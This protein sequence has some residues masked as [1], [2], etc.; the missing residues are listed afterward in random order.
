[1]YELSAKNGLIL[2]LDGLAPEGGEAQLWVI[3]ELQSNLTLRSG[4][5][6]C[7]DQPTFENFLSP[8]IKHGLKVSYVLSDKQ[9]GL[10]PAVASVFG[11]ETKHTFCQSH[12]LKNL[13]EPL[14]EAD[15]AMKV[16]LRKT[17]RIGVG[18]LIRQEGVESPGVLIVTGLLPTPI[19]EAQTEILSSTEQ[20]T[21]E[22]S[23]KTAAPAQQVSQHDDREAVVEAMMRRVRYLLSL[24]GRPPFRLAGLEMVTQLTL[25]VT[26]LDQMLAHLPESR[27]LQLRQGLQ[28]A[29]DQVQEQFLTLSIA[30]L[31]VRQI[32]DLLDPDLHPNRSSAE[33]K[34]SL[35]ALL[36]TITQQAQ[37]EPALDSF[38]A[39]LR[40]VSHSYAPGLFFSY[41]EPALPRTNN[42]RESEFRSLNQRLLRTSGQ[43]AL[44]RRTIQRSGA[45]ELIP[46]PDSLLAT[47]SA[48]SRVPTADFELERQRF[49]LHRQRFRLHSRSPV[50]VQRQLQQLLHSWSQIPPHPIACV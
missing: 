18:E 45:W 22:T 29:L 49:R 21:P 35:F 15:E 37:D 36:D 4:Y 14:A 46:R 1:M 24:K 44:A 2:G 32:A 26:C 12:Y 41:V 23:D 13:S 27:L 3:R 42:D 40:K 31:W 8:I 20:A 48:L 7:Q 6:S 25:V 10:V 16:T 5:L 43:I 47:V 38:A 17:V 30:A 11:P 19:A 28:L 50:L 39:H 34:L 9:R 33:V